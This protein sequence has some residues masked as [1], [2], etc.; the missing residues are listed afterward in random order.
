MA[1]EDGGFK[2]RNNTGMLLL[3]E[4]C[5]PGRQASQHKIYWLGVP[6]TREGS[7]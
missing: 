6:S 5:R 3:V 7:L 2:D 1:G 4:T